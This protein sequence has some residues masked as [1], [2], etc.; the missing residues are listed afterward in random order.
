MAAPA[1]ECLEY[2]SISPADARALAELQVAT[3]PPQD[4]AAIPQ[5]IE[6][7]TA[8]LLHPV[9]HLPPNASF[10]LPYA[11]PAGQRPAHLLPPRGR[12]AAFTVARLPTSHSHTAWP[13]DRDGAGSGLYGHAARGRGLGA[14]LMRETFK[15]VDSGEFSCSL[16]QTCVPSFY[17]RLG[18]RVITNR[19]V[20]SLGA[21]P[22]AR[23]F[24]DPTIMVYPKTYDWPEAR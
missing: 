1:I 12:P 3:W 6:D 15:L 2:G 20:N 11:G 23:P 14:I 7:S 4:P 10:T 18:A 5:A 22:E 19:I 13:P 16:F 9:R 8:S 17:E 21:D 24:W